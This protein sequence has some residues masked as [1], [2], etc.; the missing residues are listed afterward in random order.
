MKQTVLHSKWFAILCA[1][2]LSLAVSAQE[3]GT[4]INEALEN[5]PVIQKFELQY[6][7]ASEKVNEVNLVP[8]T[9]FSAGYFV[10]EP[11]TRTGP[12]RFKISVRQMLPWFGTV[13]SRENYVSSLADAKYE[14][15]AIAKRTLIASV[16]K[17]Y[18]RLYA[19]RAK[20]IVVSQNIE[21]LETYRTMALTS[22]ETGASSAIDVLRL[23]MRQNDLEQLRQIMDEQYIAEQSTLNILLNRSKDIEVV[24]AEGMAIP[25][26]ELVANPDNLSVHPELIKYD[27]LY[28][29][30]EQSEL[31]NNRESAPMIGFG[32]DYINVEKREGLDFKD[33]GKD[34][35]MP[36]VSVSIP[37]FNKKYKSV[38]QQN[39]WQQQ[40]VRAEKQE[41]LND[42]ETL[43][44][45]AIR[46]RNIAKIRF[47]IQ[48]KNLKQARNAEDMLIKNYET[49]TIDFN[50]VLDIQE[51][52]LKFE[53]N[54]IEAIK[55]YFMESANNN[56]LIK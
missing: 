9:E 37:I 14:D 55:T 1:C 46:G 47:G 38:T 3:L 28:E 5:N 21:L 4:L 41:R 50:D 17:S 45:K 36:M 12:Q 51:L 2:F 32:M 35:L 42:L 15:I 30:I 19:L 43:L 18:Y 26:D 24:V 10:S 39:K 44:D 40:K 16:S 29:S 20:Q 25:E 27:R 56:Y 48:S 53:M 6:S 34:V 11:E 7:V 52:Q 33:N 31:L 23:Q 54:Q 8:N 13:T 49:G 22:V